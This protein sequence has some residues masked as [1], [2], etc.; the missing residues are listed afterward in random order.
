MTSNGNQGGTSGA[1]DAVG[2]TE[3]ST[4]ALR[5]LASALVNGEV[6]TPFK[7]G[8]LSYRGLGH[9]TS[10]FAP[11]DG[12]NATALLT[13][14]RA[15]LAERRRAAAKVL[16]LVWSGSDAGPSYARYTKVVVPELIQ[17]ATRQITIAGYSFDDGSDLFD[18][19]HTAMTE[20]RVAVRLFVDI[21]QMSRRLE[22]LF[23]KAKKGKRLGPLQQARQAGADAFAKEVL[24]LFREAFWPY[25]DCAPA[26]YYDP[27]TAEQRTFAS[28]HAK[29]IIVDYAHVLITSANFTGRG[30]DRNIE[31]GIVLHDPGYAT[32]LERQWSNLVDSGDV[33]LG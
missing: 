23:K 6:A 11:F 21:D 10:A 16:D 1:E 13:V 24:S 32:T 20:R 18:H 14:I 25:S 31:V 19:L 8:A 9:L 15:V 4:D 5:Q 22:F 2:L 17:S 26:L 33:V 7:A 12:L 30:Q 3:V 29:C 27:R 28:L